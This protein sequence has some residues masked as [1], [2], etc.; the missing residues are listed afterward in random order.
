MIQ[1]TFDFYG[2]SAICSQIENGHFSA[3]HDRVSS[4]LFLKSYIH[5]PI[6]PL[7]QAWQTLLGLPSLTDLHWLHP[8]Q[9][10][11]LVS[12]SCSV[13]EPDGFA[14]LMSYHAGAC[15]WTTIGFIPVLNIRVGSHF[16]QWPKF[17]LS[18]FSSLLS[19]LYVPFIL[20]KAIP[21]WND[22]V[23]PPLRHTSSI[24][25]LIRLG[26]FL[27]VCFT[28]WQALVSLSF[29]F[30]FWIPKKQNFLSVKL[31]LQLTLTP[32]LDT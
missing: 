5:L 26:D 13:I 21:L 17:I 25:L 14:S 7:R 15:T 16:S 32:D 4:T 6:F 19:H 23:G 24:L 10:I 18:W 31:L 2:Y 28:F 22:L 11:G 29:C 8:D 30:W 20:F 1:N 12:F 27:F 3:I 9:D